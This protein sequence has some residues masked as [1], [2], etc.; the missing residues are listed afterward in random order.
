MSKGGLF[1]VYSLPGIC[2]S[3]TRTSAYSRD[4]ILQNL[5]FGILE[6]WRD[7]SSPECKSK[8]I[9]QFKSKRTFFHATF[10]ACHLKQSC[11]IMD[12]GRDN[13]MMLEVVSWAQFYWC[14]PSNVTNIGYLL[15]RWNWKG[16]N[17][18]G[19]CCC[20]DHQF[21]HWSGNNSIGAEIA[22]RTSQRTTPSH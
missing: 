18:W 6:N 7:G 2:G 10:N 12:Q 9:T 22:I 8:L 1:F 17:A 14:I 15:Y 21:G 4:F 19:K 11:T 16:K 20:F 3:L 5:E 13:T